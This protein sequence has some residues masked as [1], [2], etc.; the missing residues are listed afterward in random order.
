MGEHLAKN[1][2][3]DGKICV[4]QLFASRILPTKPPTKSP[5]FLAVPSVLKKCA[6]VIESHGIVDGIYRLSGM[7]SNIQKLR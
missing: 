5:S 1:N 2:N 3:Q 6:E 7:S 4:I